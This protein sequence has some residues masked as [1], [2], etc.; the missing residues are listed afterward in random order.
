MDR[1]Q[2][3]R[4][5]RYFKRFIVILSL[6]ILSLF[7]SVFYLREYYVLNISKSIPLGFYK[8]LKGT[9]YQKGDIVEFEIP[10]NA[11]KYVHGRSYQINQVKTLSKQIVGVTGDK[12][13]IKE[14]GRKKF[15]YINGNV[16][17]NIYSYDKSGLPLPKIKD[18][19]IKENEYF[20]MGTHPESF[21]SR[22]YGAIPKKII[23]HK[24][25]KCN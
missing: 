16:K 3:D 20:V 10:K 4:Q 6:F 23:L 1:I 9:N 8:I 2:K 5:K 21:D 17:G 24:I 13:E 25:K 11:E 12:I 22:Y 18:Q 15:L 14:K 7:L 19:V